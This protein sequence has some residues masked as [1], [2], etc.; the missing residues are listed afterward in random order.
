VYIHSIGPNISF[1]LDIATGQ[2]GSG[3]A[4]AR[5]LIDSGCSPNGFCDTRYAQRRGFRLYRLPSPRTLR[6]ADGTVAGQITEYCEVRQK[7]G[8]HTEVH[9]LAIWHLDGPD[10]ILGLPWLR[11]LNPDIDWAEGRVRIKGNTILE[12][13]AKQADLEEPPAGPKP[14]RPALKTPRV[15]PTVPHETTALR[16]AKSLRF[17]VPHTE[18]SPETAKLQPTDPRE[19]TEPLDARSPVAPSSEPTPRAPGARPR[20]PRETTKP[21][22]FKPR[23]A[24]PQPAK[25]LKTT[26]PHT[27]VFPETANPHPT[28]PQE[29]TEPLD[30]RSLQ[31]PNFLMLCRMPGV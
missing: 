16:P 12:L 15:Q 7:F 29:A 2:Q 30:V 20:L 1:I 14:L 23:P 4:P 24:L 17:I 8:D 31:A 6:L 18:V 5:C 9:R 22:P 28:D 27:E 19:V 13:G 11:R 21:R 10:I 25:S 3:L 26:G